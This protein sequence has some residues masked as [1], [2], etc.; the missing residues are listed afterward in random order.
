M[1]LLITEN[2]KIPE[3]NMSFTRH[4]Q[5]L[6]VPLYDDVNFECSLNIP[7]ER[8]A[9]HHRPLG[10][11]KWTLSSD[12]Y[13]NTGG[14]TSRLI[15]SFDN[16]SKAGDYRCIAFFGETPQKLVSYIIPILFNL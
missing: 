3:M 8:F 16:V 15:V 10:S 11:N 9:W 2:D 12:T 14:K 7:A 1:M 13:S 6:A 5:P 4:P